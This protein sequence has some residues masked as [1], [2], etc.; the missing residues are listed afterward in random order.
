MDW[1]YDEGIKYSFGLELRDTGRHAF[2]LPQDQIQDT[3]A[4]TWAGLVAMAREIAPEFG[5]SI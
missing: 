1:A 3:V 4:E 5:I 2:L